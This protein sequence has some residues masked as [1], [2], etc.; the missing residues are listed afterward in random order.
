MGTRGF[1][2]NLAET[3]ATASQSKAGGLQTSLRGCEKSQDGAQLITASANV[4]AKM[5]VPKET[6]AGATVA[7][8]SGQNKYLSEFMRLWGSWKTM[9]SSI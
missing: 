7:L 4:E 5:Q 6:T 2:N 9:E 8:Q 1:S 3:T